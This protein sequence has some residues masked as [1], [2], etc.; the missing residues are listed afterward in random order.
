MRFLLALF[1]MILLPGIANAKCT[2]SVTDL[3]QCAFG[4]P[5]A[6]N[7]MPDTDKLQ[8]ISHST[9]T[10]LNKGDMYA[11]TI[12]CSVDDKFDGPEWN[13]FVSTNLVTSHIVALTTSRLA[14]QDLPTPDKSRASITVFS[15]AGDDKSKNVFLNKN[16]RTE[17]LISGRETL[18]VAT[19]ANQATTNSPGV[20]TNLIYQVIQVAIPILPLIKGTALATTIL[21]DVAK[22]ED[23]LKKVFTELDKGLTVTKSDDLFLGD[24]IVTTPYSRVN[25]RINKVKSLLGPAYSDYLKVFED[26]TDAAEANL[27]LDSAGDPK[28][29][30]EDFATGLR[31][32]NFAASDIA[33]ALV[34]VSQAASLDKKKTLDCIGA[35][36]V[37]AAL[38]TAVASAWD[39]YG[40]VLYTKADAKS[41]FAKESGGAIPAQPKFTAFKNRLEYATAAIGGYLQRLGGGPSKVPDYYSTPIHLSNKTD[42]YSDNTGESDLPLADVM[43]NLVDKKF[44]RAGCL[45]S[46]N[47]AVAAFALF[48]G[49]D[50]NAKQ[51]Q[52][53][54]DD[55]IIM[56][57]WYNE[58][59]SIGWI[60]LSFDADALEKAMSGKPTRFCGPNLEVLPIKK[61]AA[62]SAANGGK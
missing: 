38:D 58:N 21:T 53:S 17:F 59:Q 16:C 27:Q 10:P 60:D 50:G 6:A 37:L 12:I 43:K 28:K 45:M 57:V 1:L 9:H 22:T 52:F 56:R 11:A 5:P 20:V 47:D 32:R 3:F 61:E 14:K 39:R 18:F 55:S 4:K 44:R 15:V 8:S 48:R 49:T 41:Y 19:T 35:K 23:P 36:Y 2:D 54:V 34:S 31:G 24:N 42:M 26:A 29:K 25:I 7:H 46:D 62:V 40:D 30:C 33:Y 13:P 51:R